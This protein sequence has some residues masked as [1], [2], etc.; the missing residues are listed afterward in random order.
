MAEPVDLILPLLREMRTESASRH[1][2]VI[3]RL[4]AVERAQVSFKHALTS[5]T[6]LSRLLTGEFEE[7]IEAL[8]RK[9]RELQ[10]A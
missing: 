4:D 3:A 5:D 10:G 1:S 8:E 7:G 2:E 9:V 6:L